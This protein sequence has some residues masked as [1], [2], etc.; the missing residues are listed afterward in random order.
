MSLVSQSHDE[1][2][3]PTEVTQKIPPI[4]AQNILDYEHYHKS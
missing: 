2:Q 1:D 4:Y 3:Q